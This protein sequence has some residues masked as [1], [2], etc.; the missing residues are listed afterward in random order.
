ML[1]V[2]D[3]AIVIIIII[4][5]VRHSTRLDSTLLE[6]KNYVTGDTVICFDD[7]QGMLTSPHVLVEFVYLRA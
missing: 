3:W 4:I 2:V 6:C 1:D 7:Y 5:Y